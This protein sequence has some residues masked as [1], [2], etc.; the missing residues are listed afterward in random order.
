MRWPQR[1]NCVFQ[2]DVETCPKCGG[3]IKIIACIEDPPVIE[4]IG[5]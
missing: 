5:S 1:L 3:T 4:R 2:I